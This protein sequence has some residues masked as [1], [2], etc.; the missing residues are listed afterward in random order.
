MTNAHSLAPLAEERST[1]LQ[2][3]TVR[4]IIAFGKV[5]AMTHQYATRAEIMSGERLT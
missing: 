2:G 1:L 5:I 3:S 4:R